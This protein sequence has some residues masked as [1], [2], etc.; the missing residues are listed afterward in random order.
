[1]MNEECRAG[2]GMRWRWVSWKA[3]AACCPLLLVSVRSSEYMISIW[4]SNHTFHPELLDTSHSQ[5]V[6]CLVS[7]TIK[8]WITNPFE[9][10]IK[11]VHTLS[12]KEKNAHISKT[13]PKDTVVRSDFIHH[14]PK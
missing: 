13:L 1:M 3:R 5:N 14:S 4:Y 10:I 8:I 11:T 7:P 2:P 9:Y 12:P 6:Y